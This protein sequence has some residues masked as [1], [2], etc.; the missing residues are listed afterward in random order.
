[1]DIKQVEEFHIDMI[2][3]EMFAQSVKTASN[4]RR[5]MLYTLYV[6]FCNEYSYQALPAYM[7]HRA[8][9]KLINFSTVTVEGIKLMSVNS[10]PDYE[11]ASSFIG[12]LKKSRFIYRSDLYQMYVDKAKLSKRP[13]MSNRN[14][15]Q[16]CAL[17][18]RLVYK[19]RNDGRG[20]EVTYE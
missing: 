15:Y 4:V 6:G 1:M 5:S 12:S 7:F 19:R 10:D 17:H 14:F 16:V 13:P 20:Y 9:K 8:I 3:I 11:Y 18:D 2:G